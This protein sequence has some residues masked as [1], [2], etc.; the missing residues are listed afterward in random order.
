M[1]EMMENVMGEQFTTNALTVVS[2]KAV[3]TIIAADPN[4]ILGKLAAKVAAHRP[5]ISTERGRAEMRSLAAQIASAKM[6]LIRLG[7]GLTEGWRESTKA[8]N[9]ECKIIEDRMDALKEQVRA[10]LTEWENREKNR[11]AGHEAALAAILEHPEWGRAESSDDIARRL[12]HLREYPARDWQEFQHRAEAALAAEIA[13]AEHAHTIALRR[14]AEVAELA[15]LRAEADERAR[16]D[17]LRAQAERD[18]RIAKEAAERARLE[19]EAEAERQRQETLRTAAEERARV[20]REA[21]AERERAEV[22]RLAVVREREAAEARALKAEQDRIDA[23]ARAA[24]ERDAARQKA[25]ADRIAAAEA[26]DLAQQ[27]AVDAER[28]RAADAKAAEEAEAARR[29][30]N[31]AHKGKIN[32]EALADL[33]GCGVDEAVGKII[34]ASIIRGEVRH[35]SV[36]Y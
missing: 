13:R 26:A 31:V 4:D 34:L 7:K 15:R 1:S 32:R 5:D 29:A 2:A 19:A 22:A 24:T 33:V 25:E 23:E 20:E 21:A 17:A 8:V 9:A 35:V 12:T 18:A 30:A 10:P 36:R 14:E 27:R 3:S 16:Q 6:D 28:K 11:V